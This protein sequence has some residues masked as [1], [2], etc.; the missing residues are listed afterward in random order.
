MELLLTKRSVPH[1][2][3]YYSYNLFGRHDSSLKTIEDTSCVLALSYDS[4]RTMSAL[5]P[6]CITQMLDR[7]A[8]LAQRLLDEW[9]IIE[10]T[11]CFQKCIVIERA[12]GDPPG[13]TFA[14]V[15]L[16]A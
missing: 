2:L 7:V 15:L 16:I 1:V 12:F 5:C 14:S 6:N 9:K 3:L 10:C 11:L 13:L 4:R 8:R